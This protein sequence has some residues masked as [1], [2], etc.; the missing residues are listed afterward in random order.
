M[1]ASMEDLRK[2]GVY[3]AITFLPAAFTSSIIVPLSLR[4]Y[5]T[6]HREEGQSGILRNQDEVGVS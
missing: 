4:V 1:K 2:S 3:K 6:V 5:V